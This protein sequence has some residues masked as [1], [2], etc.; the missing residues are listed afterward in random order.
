VGSPQRAV[1]L[2]TR[3]LSG[4]DDKASAT[5]QAL[6]LERVAWANARLGEKV[7]TE[8]TLAEVERVFAQ[9][10]ADHDPS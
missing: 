6:L 7:T 2:A 5:A 3:A 1:L 9:Q 8:R 10:N 4:L